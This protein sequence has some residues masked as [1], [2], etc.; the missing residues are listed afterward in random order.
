MDYLGGAQEILE[1][2]RGPH[3][4][5]AHKA[6]HPWMHTYHLYNAAGM[7]DIN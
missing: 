3:D 7:S 1:G 2:A 6:R 4:H 5:R